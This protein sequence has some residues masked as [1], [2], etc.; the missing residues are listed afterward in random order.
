[1][2]QPRQTNSYQL[3]LLSSAAVFCWMVVYAF[4][5]WL[6]FDLMASDAAGYWKEANSLI[7]SGYD[8][9]VIYTVFHHDH[10][11]GF[12]ILI[13]LGRTIL[14]S[15]NPLFI[16]Q[17]IIMIAWILSI[18]CVH[19][20][21]RTLNLSHAWL[22]T[23]FFIIYPLVG[24]TYVVYPIADNLAMLAVAAALLGLL[25][26]NKVLLAV[27]LATGPLIHKATWPMLGLIVLLGLWRRRDRVWMLLPLGVPLLVYWFYGLHYTHDWLWIL[28]RYPKFMSRR[29]ALPLFDGLFGPIL[30][31]G[32]LKDW[33][34]S[35]VV[36]S[37]YGTAVWLLIRGTWRRAP[38]M[39]SIIIPILLW[40]GLYIAI[41]IWPLVR[42]GNLLVIP[43]WLHLH[44][45]VFTKDSTRTDRLPHRVV[46]IGLIS[47]SVLSQFAW[48]YY[49]TTFLYEH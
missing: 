11:P 35:L 4:F 7:S 23:L 13:A 8:L 16:M 12:P 15:L 31:R 20:I 26:D 14:P 40:G 22:G 17:A 21:F 25:K 38:V 42:F 39:L 32:S 44:E 49:M 36:M 34:K 47:M 45:K 33:I 10:V 3:T 6:H 48:A 19:L 28:G 18:V 9:S 2:L 29:T 5:A 41:M 1:M 37:V 43:L 24:V 27:S 30:A 46:W